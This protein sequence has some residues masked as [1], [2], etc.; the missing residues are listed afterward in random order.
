M[1]TNKIKKISV[2]FPNIVN[3]LD[4]DYEGKRMVIP[5]LLEVREL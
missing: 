3:R 2:K 4:I 1:N 5:T